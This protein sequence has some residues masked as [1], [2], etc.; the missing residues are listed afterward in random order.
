MLSNQKFILEGASNKEFALDITYSD[1]QNNNGTIIFCHGFKGFKDWG[2]WQMI[3]NYFAD[4][5][6]AFVKFNFSYNGMGLEEST[7]FTELDKFASNTLSKEMED[8]ASVEEFLMGDIPSIST[9]LN[10]DKMFIIG[11]SKGGVS[12]LLYCTQYKTNIQKVC[13]WASPF[14]FYRSW[15][16]EF[17]TK[18]RTDGIQYIKNARTKQ[19][20][21]LSLSVLEDMEI[22]KDKYSLVHAGKKLDIPLLIVQGTS[23]VAVKMEEA[24]LLKKHFT[25]G[26]LHI[27]E[28]ANHVF[29]GSHPFT[30]D[31]LPKDT[32][33][34]VQVT[35]HFFID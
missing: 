10:T 17:I 30:E 15:N 20:M 5:G 25:G 32:D 31:S 13:T 28:G 35:K 23:D 27:I 7:E 3:A 1:T 16:S 4:N 34:L 11:H 33:E 2:S 18:W 21:P 6:F 29:G 26:T 8:I 24:K 9:L 14:D 19:L 12:S 22:N